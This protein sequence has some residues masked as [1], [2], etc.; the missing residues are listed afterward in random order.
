MKLKTRQT[1][2]ISSTLVGVGLVQATPLLAHEKHFHVPNKTTKP[3][4]ESAQTQK[5]PATVMPDVK[6]QQEFSNPPHQKVVNSVSAAQTN[7]RDIILQPG[8]FVLLLLLG[9]TFLLFYL[10][11]FMY[12]EKN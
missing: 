6:V 1:I 9:G 10:K 8:E 11:R 4:S 3:K 5:T 2:C 12:R 7:E